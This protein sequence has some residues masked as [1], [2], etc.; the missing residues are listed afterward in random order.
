MVT[1]ATSTEE[2]R[3]VADAILSQ[4]LPAGHLSVRLL[5]MGVSGLDDTG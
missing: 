1:A 4:R 2:F 5:G 3:R